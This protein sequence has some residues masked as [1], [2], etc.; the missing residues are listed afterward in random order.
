MEQNS[1]FHDRYKLE[2]L[3]GRGAYSEVWL[4]RD[5]K[6]NVSFALKIFAPATGLD[7][8]GL[9]MFA[10][11]FTLVVGISDPNIL[12]PQHYDTC[13]RKPYL[14][15][16]YCKEGSVKSGIG[17][18]SEEEAW[19]ILL[20]V[21]RGLKALHSKVPPIIHQDIKPDNI[22]VSDDG[23]YMITDF[24]VSTHLHTTLRKSVSATLTSA[25]TRAYMAPERYSKHKTPIMASDIYSLGATVYELLD[26]DAPFGDD[27][28]L[29]QKGGADIPELEGNFSV[30]LKS[31]IEQ[32]LSLNP[33]ER[34]DAEQ[35]ERIV[36]NR[37]DGIANFTNGESDNLIE[38][39][40]KDKLSL[41]NV[42]IAI[43]SGIIAGILLGIFI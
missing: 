14:V 17:K 32:C 4:A 13:D 39:N 35:L 9:E 36:M 31:V 34:P 28:G 21:A 25:G 23:H 33:W 18:I 5:I 37:Q 29:I 11:E 30:A 42:S 2:K 22:M 10:R 8:Y 19:K 38:R 40:G 15:L 16:P 20:D 41:V 3:L 26:G 43:V 24:G 7:D 27:G 1:I 6:T 12:K